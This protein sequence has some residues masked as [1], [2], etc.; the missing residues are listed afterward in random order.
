M[1]HS[2]EAP[3]NRTA[4]HDL[5][6]GHSDSSKQD[7]TPTRVRVAPVLVEPLDDAPPS[8]WFPP[9]SVHSCD[10][11]HTIKTGA[12]YLG[13]DPESLRARCELAAERGQDTVRL[14]KGVT[15]RRVGESWCIRI[16][17]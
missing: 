1:N 7:V 13:V 8:S 10:P 17:G 3:S 14:G 2:D 4:G 15:A 16:V 11:E 6:N 5:A 9:S 12:A